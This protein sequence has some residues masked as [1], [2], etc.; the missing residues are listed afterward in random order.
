MLPLDQLPLGSTCTVGVSSLDP[1]SITRRQVPAK[2]IFNSSEVCSPLDPDIIR[3]DLHTYL[4]VSLGSLPGIKVEGQL[5][6]STLA[7]HPTLPLRH[8][9]TPYGSP[10]PFSSSHC[11]YPT[12]F[13][14]VSSP[15][16]V[17]PVD[18]LSSTLQGL[19]PNLIPALQFPRSRSTVSPSSPSYPSLLHTHVSHTPVSH[20]P[21]A[22]PSFSYPTPVIPS[23]SSTSFL[24]SRPSSDMG[25]GPS[26][27]S[28]AFTSTGSDLPRV[29]SPTLP[30]SPSL[31]PMAPPSSLPLPL[32]PVSVSLPV[33]SI[34]VTS[35]STI[36]STLASCPS[37]RWVSQS[38][39]P[40]A[41]SMP[42]PFLPWSP[43][44]PGPIFSGDMPTISL[45]LPSS[46]SPSTSSQFV[47]T[48]SHTSSP[49]APP[50]PIPPLLVTSHVGARSVCRPSSSALHSSPL[51][52]SVDLSSSGILHTP[53]GTFSPG[54]LLSPISPAV[55]TSCRDLPSL[56][57]MSTTAVQVLSPSSIPS[58]SLSSIY[59][60]S[61]TSLPH[62]VASCTQTA[63]TSR[64]SYRV[65]PYVSTTTASRISSNV[66]P[67]TSL[68]A[69]ALPIGGPLLTTAT[70]SPSSPSN[71]GYTAVTSPVSS[72]SELY[73]L[74]SG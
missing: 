48:L 44:T 11:P 24:P 5:P 14:P 34:P 13:G 50:L 25:P 22:H 1:P 58:L 42:V 56:A 49:S 28:P 38:M 10:L 62:Y 74:H 68:T 19:S 16:S 72:S 73:S 2:L 4:G 41:V 9:P 64:R 23:S 30:S 69:T 37:H 53:T 15:W 67:A 6:L 59:P 26:F 66:L 40:L 55:S 47:S 36:P 63:S 51:T 3:S 32:P 57:S 7:T 54:L 45:A 27:R 52:S 17:A 12:S 46:L 60:G 21:L 20:P 35:S 31:V 8:P 65:H 33:L 18:P 43:L 71:P 29:A 39:N 61:P 70:S